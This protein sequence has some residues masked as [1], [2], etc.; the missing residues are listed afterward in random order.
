MVSS[1]SA[2]GGVFDDAGR[3]EKA[4]HE[5]FSTKTMVASPSDESVGEV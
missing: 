2:Q 4:G 5:L 3:A 1:A